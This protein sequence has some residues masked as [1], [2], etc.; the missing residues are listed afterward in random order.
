MLVLRR[1]AEKARHDALEQ[2]NEKLLRVL[3]GEKK[4]L[5][6]LVAPGPKLAEQVRTLL[7][8]IKDYEEGAFAPLSQHPVV[9]AL[10]MP[11][12]G[13]GI[14]TLLDFLAAR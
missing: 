3:G 4:L 14:L 11:F 13:A 12:G 8:K 1:A 6:P 2:L 9:A 7:Q 10:A 5:A